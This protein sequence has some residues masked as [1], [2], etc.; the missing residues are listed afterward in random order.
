MTLRGVAVHR[1]RDRGLGLPGEELRVVADIGDERRH[2][3]VAASGDRAQPH[4]AHPV[5]HGPEATGKQPQHD[6]E[7][8]AAARE[9]EEETEPLRHDGREPHRALQED[10][11]HDR[12]RNRAQPADDHHRERADALDRSEDV[13]AECLLMEHEHAARERREEAGQREREQLDARRAESECL[14]VPFVLARRDEV[15]HVPRSLEPADGDEHEEQRED[16]H[17]IEVA[18]GMRPAVADPDMTEWCP[19][20]E[21]RDAIEEVVG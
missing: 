8:D 19:L 15:A 7:P 5:Q 4:V 14:C 13:L 9:L 18:L 17:E 1:H 10:R 11:A 6:D 12:A 16:G 2:D 20:R 21:S 3:E